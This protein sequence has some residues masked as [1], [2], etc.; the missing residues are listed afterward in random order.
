MIT[1][2]ARM[3]EHIYLL[4][5]CLH[6]ELHETMHGTWHPEDVNVSLWHILVGSHGHKGCEGGGKAY[7][8]LSR[9]SRPD[10]ETVI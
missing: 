8:T 1:N 3:C 5:R 4:A 10:L 9:Q 6:A 7:Q 2:Y